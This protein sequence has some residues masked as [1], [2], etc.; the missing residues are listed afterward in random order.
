[1]F[2]PDLRPRAPPIAPCPPE[3][4]PLSG[5]SGKGLRGK[6]TDAGARKQGRGSIFARLS[7]S[8]RSVDRGVLD[9]AIEKKKARKKAEILFGQGYKSINN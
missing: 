4:E 2:S 6:T 1:M 9:D 7:T 8:D 3:P 5:P